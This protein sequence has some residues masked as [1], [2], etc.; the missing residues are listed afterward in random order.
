MCMSAS[1]QLPVELLCVPG[2]ACTKTGVAPA[3]H[4]SGSA[5]TGWVP[6]TVLGATQEVPPTFIPRWT[7]GPI[8]SL[9]PSFFWCPPLWHV[10]IK[11]VF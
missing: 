5:V 1:H 3:G 11:A 10:R 6:V 4:E 9:Y 2:D 8:A 7:L